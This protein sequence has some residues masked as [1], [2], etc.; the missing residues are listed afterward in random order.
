MP[1]LDARWDAGL[2]LHARATTTN[3]FWLFYC[4]V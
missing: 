2:R 4:V 3:R 1:K